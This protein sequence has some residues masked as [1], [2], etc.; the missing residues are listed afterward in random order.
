MGAPAVVVMVV[1]MPIAMRP[2]PMRP[3]GRVVARA[4]AHDSDPIR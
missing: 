3:V 4:G 2:M 1:T